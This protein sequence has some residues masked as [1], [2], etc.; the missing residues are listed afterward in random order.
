MKLYI[1]T[2]NDELKDLYSKRSNFIEDSGIDLYCPKDIIIAPRSQAKIEFEIKC[3]MQCQTNKYEAYFLLPRSS[4]V[5]T[6]LRMS[7]SIGLIDKNYTGM[8]MAFV[9]NISD[10]EYSIK[11][12]DKLF[13][14]AHSSLCSL[15]V[16]LTN[17]LRKTERGEGGFGST[18]KIITNGNINIGC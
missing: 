13:Q 2:E 16:E 15:E 7:N 5:K 10:K 6:P 9:D 4:I 8:I 14:I 1:F 17:E 18:N 12:G 11:K 3:Q